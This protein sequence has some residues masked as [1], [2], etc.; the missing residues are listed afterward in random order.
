VYVCSPCGEREALRQERGEVIPLTDWPL[1][2]DALAE[3]DELTRS[4]TLLS[5]DDLRDMLGGND[6]DDELR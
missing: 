5:P 3:E 1:S 4:G 6:D 2:P